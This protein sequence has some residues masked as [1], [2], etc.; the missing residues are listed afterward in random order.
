[1]AVRTGAGTGVIV[2]LVVFVLTTVFLLVLTIVFYAGKQKELEARTAAEAALDKYVLPA[3]RNADL[4]KG[5]E[6]SAP[7]GS[8]VAQYL[9]QRYDDLLGYVGAQPNASLETVKQDFA[10]YQMKEGD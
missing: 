1:M 4:Y 2:S 5:F 3:Q 8:S 7:R 9:N 10:R 6:A